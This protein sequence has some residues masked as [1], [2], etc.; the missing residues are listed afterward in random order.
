VGR[1]DLVLEAVAVQMVVLEQ[2]V[3]RLLQLVVVADGMTE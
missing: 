3:D 1:E 2:L